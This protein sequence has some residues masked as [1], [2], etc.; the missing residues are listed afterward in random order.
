MGRVR[1]VVVDSLLDAELPGATVHLAPLGRTAETDSAG[2]FALD[3]VP[4]GEWLVSFR[5]PSLDSLGLTDAGTRVRVFAGATTTVTLA[6][7]SFEALRNPFCG[8]TPDSLSETL[9]YGTVHSADGQRVR[10]NV[11]VTW[12]S[13]ADHESAPRPGTV[14]TITEG[15]RQVWVACGVPWGAWIHATMRDSTRAASA[16]IPLGP[17]GVVVRNLVLSTGRTRITGTVRD[18]D[19][20]RVAGARVSVAGTEVAAETNSTGAFVL[21]DAPNGTVTIDVR[22]AGY[23]PWLAALEGG[24]PGADVVDVRLQPPVERDEGGPRGS[25]YLRLLERSASPGVQLLAGAALAGDSTALEQIV[26][27]G[28]C[29]WWLDGR[30]VDREFFL[31]QPRRLWRAIELYRLGADAPPEYR[32]GACP[33]ALLWTATADW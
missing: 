16:F 22:A 13:T 8:D 31:A 32:T 7:R 28:T 27:P 17:R 14:R 33:V 4:P 21:Q 1:G 30:P 12:M 26:L 15:E 6:T 3:R 19:G 2:R 18:P 23:R 5:H 10:V 20:R 25:D 11:S 24:P 9:A 29:R